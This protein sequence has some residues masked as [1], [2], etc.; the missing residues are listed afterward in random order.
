[1]KLTNNI[2][3]YFLSCL[4]IKADEEFN[5]LLVCEIDSLVFG[6][7]HKL[8][9]KREYANAETSEVDNSL[10]STRDFLL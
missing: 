1:M 2:G 5:E 4:F 6:G 9:N 7:S 10:L 8:P 3:K